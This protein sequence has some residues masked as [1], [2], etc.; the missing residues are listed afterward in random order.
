MDLTELSVATMRIW[1]ASHLPRQRLFPLLF[2][3]LLFTTSL[4]DI[5]SAKKSSPKI[6]RTDF[7]NPL[8]G[9]FYFKDSEVVLAYDSRVGE[10]HR[11]IDAGEHWKAVKDIPRGRVA[12]LWQHPYD[13]NKAYVLSG[14]HRHWYTHDRGETWTPFKTAATPSLSR[15]PLSFHAGDSDK[16]IYLGIA[17]HGLF[18]CEEVVS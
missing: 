5:A 15:P 9:L 2:G 17:C 7:E 18:D 11:S 14:G 1:D 4:V 12:E 10:L 8:H 6:S 16:I 13:R 3:L